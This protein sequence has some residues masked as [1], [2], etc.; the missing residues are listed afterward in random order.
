MSLSEL[1]PIYLLAQRREREAK[2]SW[3]E[4][5]AALSVVTQDVSQ[6]MLDAT[7]VQVD[8]GEH[9][10]RIQKVT[11]ERVQP[12]TVEGRDQILGELLDPVTAQHVI[13]RLNDK[14]GR[15]KTVS[16]RVVVKK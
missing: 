1:I 16:T 9:Q 15:A 12:L 7:E 3:D 8:D 4:A 13:D 5:A 10:L 6:A 11:S 2:W 14:T